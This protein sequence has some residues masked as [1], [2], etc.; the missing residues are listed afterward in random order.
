M[1]GPHTHVI[2]T[3]PR[4]DDSL[5]AAWK[6]FETDNDATLRTPKQ[7]GANW[8][9]TLPWGILRHDDAGMLLMIAKRQVRDHQRKSP[10]A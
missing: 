7:T 6:T 5:L 8:E 3:L 1:V 2:P 4:G 10:E 9:V